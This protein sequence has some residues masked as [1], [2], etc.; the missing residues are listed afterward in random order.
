[1]RL[2]V[3]LALL[4]CATISNVVAQR[5]TLLTQ[6]G[7]EAANADSVLVR[8]DDGTWREVE[9]RDGHYRIDVDTGTYTVAVLCFEASG[10]H[11]TLYRFPIREM[12]LLRHVCEG[13]ND[14]LATRRRLHGSIAGT[15]SQ[16][17]RSVEEVQLTF[18]RW[19]LYLG[20]AQEEAA[21]EAL[22]APGP[23]RDLLALRVPLG[24]PPDRAVLVRD[25]PL[26]DETRIDIDFQTPN[27]LPLE[28]FDLTIDDPTGVT[29]MA[30][31]HTCNG[32]HGQ[33]EAVAP[34]GRSSTEYA[35]LPH[36]ARRACDRYERAA[37][38]LAP[39]ELEEMRVALA[40]DREP[41]DTRLSLPPRVAPPHLDVLAAEPLWVRMRWEA[42]P[43]ATLYTGGLTDGTVR[44]SFV[45]SASLPPNVTLPAWND[46]L[47][48][49]RLRG[50]PID[51]GIG[52]LRSDGDAAAALHAWEQ[53]HVLGKGRFGDPVVD[54]LTL[55]GSFLGGS[56][57]P[58]VP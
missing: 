46:D 38:A 39:N 52:M 26:R 44:W 25:L 9:G 23:P 57:V 5:I 36:P 45:Q 48:V 24:R 40:F 35:A 55:E 47:S 53:S 16:M 18:G 28:R 37:L 1:M 56:W 41:T 4:L 33:L 12:P 22:V 11:V 34:P 7:E 29:L 20:I 3:L 8:S 10:P 43:D 17:E 13:E 14:L 32:T 54:G 19:P 15:S 31:L 27:A 30:R 50:G 21:Y 49:L 42:I 58:A 2:P 51:W 6:Y